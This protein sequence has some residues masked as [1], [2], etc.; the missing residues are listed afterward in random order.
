[1]FRTCK[2][3]VMIRRFIS[4]RGINILARNTSD[5]YINFFEPREK[6]SW[7][8]TRVFPSAQ[9]LTG[10]P[11]HTKNKTSCCSSPADL[12]INQLLRSPNLQA[13]QCFAAHVAKRLAWHMF[14]FRGSNVQQKRTQK[15]FHYGVAHLWDWFR[16]S[17]SQLPISRVVIS[18]QATNWSTDIAAIHH[19][20]IFGEVWNKFLFTVSIPWK[21]NPRWKKLGFL[22]RP[23]FKEIIICVTKAY[24]FC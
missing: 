4:N 1:L 14:P 5:S 15:R 22:Q 2:K 16:R 17:I 21:I 8:N 23:F 6:V 20:S 11:T 12:I 7:G 9:F 18:T 13:I 3:C 19:W 10:Y 24:I